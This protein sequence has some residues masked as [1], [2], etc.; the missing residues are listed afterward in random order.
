[1]GAIAVQLTAGKQSTATLALIPADQA[2]DQDGDGVMDV[3]DNCPGRANPDQ[4][5]EGG[6][7]MGDDCGGG[8]DGSSPT[9]TR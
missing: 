3:I 6:D 1:M 5:D 4:R 7:G 9:P 2:T 8:P